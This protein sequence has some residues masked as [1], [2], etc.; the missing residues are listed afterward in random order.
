MNRK[1]GRTKGIYLRVNDEVRDDIK[2]RLQLGF[3]ISEWFEKKYTES[4]LH[5]Q[6][7]LEKMQ[8]LKQE[9]QVY[10]SSLNKIDKEEEKQAKVTLQT[11]EIMRLRK[12]VEKFN[13]LDTQWK[14]FVYVAKREDISKEE[15][16]KVKERYCYI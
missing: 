8:E 4:F 3:N 7:I 9:M 16:V 12:V 5:K 1:T 11:I 2:K 14:A 6:Q 10:E 15:F 13:D